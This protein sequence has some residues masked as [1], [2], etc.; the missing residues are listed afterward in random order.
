MNQSTIKWI[1]VII[2][3]FVILF[4]CVAL[5][6]F[7]NSNPQTSINNLE[8]ETNVEFKKEAKEDDIV[9]DPLKIDTQNWKKHIFYYKI[10]VDLPGSWYS[11]SESK[12]QMSTKT[13]DYLIA[14]SKTDSKELAERIS[15]KI[16][17]INEITY[18][19]GI[20]TFLDIKYEIGTDAIS[21]HQKKIKAAGRRYTIQ[22]VSIDN[23]KYTRLEVPNKCIGDWCKNGWS[24]WFVPI[25]DDF[26]VFEVN[27]NAVKDE[28]MAA[29]INSI[30]ELDANTITNMKDSLSLS[31]TEITYFASI[32]NNPKICDLIKESNEKEMCKGNCDIFTGVNK[33]ICTRINFIK[34]KELT[35]ENI[36]E[37]CSSNIVND[38]ISCLEYLT[39]IIN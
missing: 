3:I 26:I 31:N 13:M 35:S 37:Y 36:V 21:K 16:S 20:V 22:D 4:G 33:D 27:N 30:T 14:F 32:S 18:R 38:E 10:E 29:I 7:L 8:K 6:Y 23:I 28:E 34:E 17:D 5:I 15:E 1:F 9:L 39:A 19:S 2:I 24:E 12:R 11:E 25:K